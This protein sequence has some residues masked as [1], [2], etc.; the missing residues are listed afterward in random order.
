MPAVLQRKYPDIVLFLLLPPL[1]F[2]SA[3]QMDSRQLSRD[4]LPTGA[5][6]REV[7]APHRLATLVEGESLLNDGKALVLYR[8]SWG[9]WPR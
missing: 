4:W 9:S 6:F 3:Y 7:G 2:E 8:F 5:L 1:V